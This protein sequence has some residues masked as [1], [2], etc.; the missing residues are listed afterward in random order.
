MKH[1]I[2]LLLEM[3]HRLTK[4]IPQVLYFL[5]SCSPYLIFLVPDSSLNQHTTT[6]NGS[7]SITSLPHIM[8]I[9]FIPHPRAYHV[10]TKIIATDFSQIIR[11]ILNHITSFLEKM[12][13]SITIE[14]RLIVSLVF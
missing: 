5:P 1:Q 3:R 14:C 9:T 8:V 2:F 6:T 7:Q 13:Y 11:L 12:T 10:L 4:M